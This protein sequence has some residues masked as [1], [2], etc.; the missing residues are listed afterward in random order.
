MSLCRRND[1]VP[2]SYVHICRRLLV[3]GL[4]VAALAAS[5]VVIGCSTSGND[6]TGPQQTPALEVIAISPDDQATSIPV[7]AN[8]IAT[9]NRPVDPAS[10][11]TDLNLDTLLRYF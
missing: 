9:F 4:L 7:F 3:T 10:I 1:T 5:V 11:I 8:I 6:P 2:G